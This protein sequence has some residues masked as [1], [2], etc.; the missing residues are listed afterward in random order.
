MTSAKVKPPISP[1]LLNQ[2]DVRV[3]TILGL[4]EC[5]IGF[6][7]ELSERFW[8]VLIHEK[9]IYNSVA[10]SLS[11]RTSSFNGFQQI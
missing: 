6:H 1:E 9:S 4:R 7:D 2:I 3:G 5:P 10:W 8:Q 11:D